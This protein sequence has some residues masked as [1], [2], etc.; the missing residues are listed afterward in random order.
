MKKLLKILGITLLSI[1]ILL[2]VLPIFFKGKIL[3][4][5]VEAAN[6]NL[7]AKFTLE[8]VSISFI[9]SFPN[10]TVTL[11]NMKIEGLGA[12]EGVT[13]AGVDAIETTVDISSLF[14]DEIHLKRLAVV[15]PEINVLVTAAGLANYD[16]AKEGEVELEED[17]IEVE[18]GEAEL[19]VQL[20]EY[21]I[22][23]G[24]ILYEDLTMPVRAEI[25]SLDHSGSGDLSASKYIL[26][27]LT[28]A[29]SVDVVY[30]GVRYLKNVDTEIK[31]DLDIDMDQMLFAFKENSFR[32]NELVLNADGWIKMPED[33]IDMDIAFDTEQTDFRNILSLVPAAFA[34]DLEGVDVTGE[35][36]L[37]GFV[38]GKFNDTSMP[39]FGVNLLIDDGRFKYPDLPSSV[40]EINVRASIDASDGNDYDKMKIDVDR[41]YM[42]MADN[43]IDATLKLRTPMSDPDIDSKIIAKVNFET[44]KDVVPLD[45][46]D[47]LQGYLNSNIRLK[48]KLSAI[49]EERYEDFQAEGDMILQQMTYSSDSLP[50]DVEIDKAYMRFTPESINLDQFSSKIGESD[51]SLEGSID[52]Y[53]AYALKDE[54]LHGRFKMSSQML[55]LN[56]F[57]VSSE[58]SAQENG[59]DATPATEETSSDEGVIAVPGNIDFV[60]RTDIKEML[61]DNIEITNVKGLAVVADHQVNLSGVT[62]DVL[63]GKVAMTGLYDTKDISKPKSAFS[64]DIQNMGIKEAA[65]KFNTIDKLAPIA[66]SCIGTFSS[67][68][69][70]DSELDESMMPN[71]ETLLGKGDFYTSEVAVAQ[72]KPL[73]ELASQLNM[74]SVASQTFQN[75]KTYFTIENGKAFF[76]PFDVNIDG[77]PATIEGATTLTGGIDYSMNMEVPYD[78]I[79][80]SLANQA[81]DALS[82]L[83]A[84][85]GTDFSAGDKVP[86]NIKI[87]GTV[88]EPKIALDYGDLIKGKQEEIKDQIK[89]AVEEEIKEQIEDVKNDALEE[90]QKKADEILAEAQK[91]SDALI[92]EAKKAAEDLRKSGY[93][94][95]QKIEDSA[96]NP[97]EKAG[98]KIAA[99]KLRQEADEAA[100]R[101]IEEAKK[102]AKLITDRAQ[103]EADE[104][105]EKAK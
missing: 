3:D 30:D 29:V 89:D 26:N 92:A 93:A 22:T 81:N 98:A 11:E 2:L 74:G 31:A 41:F 54:L 95:A 65:E 78:R 39:G 60:L 45:A 85:L 1:F 4:A 66:K 9:S 96:K 83:N 88:T 12:F 52:N 23:G 102:Q 8:D 94:E 27:T 71:L 38:K 40:D 86:V 82:Q 42:V 59:T 10:V 46:G 79:S 75:V 101:M 35:M 36:G 104:L 15:N 50:Y 43:P 37:D 77:M 6:D 53:L 44:L 64:Y 76:E 14:G 25:K 63:G 55:N 24:N 51:I 68:L 48:G 62:M 99:N 17:G 70:L 84:Q 5:V 32:L 87:T 69:S 103:K 100:K 56:E 28:K 33:D 90:A 20:Q 67:K 7:N 72:F 18:T 34:S 21:S 57:M 49:E 105:I 58:A 73:T 80:S 19:E 13:L 91:K 16:I 97:L 61:Y 47:E